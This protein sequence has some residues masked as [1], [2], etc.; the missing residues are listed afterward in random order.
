MVSKDAELP[1]ARQCKL[2]GIS[3][4]SWY[5]RAVVESAENLVL[6]RELDGLHLQ[7]P[8]LGSRQ[9]TAQL[10]RQGRRVNRKRVSRLMKR[11][12][13]E[14]SYPKKRTSK[15]AVGHTLYPYLLTNMTPDR[16]N[17]AWAAD[18]TYIPMAKG[19]CYLM[20][21]MD[22]YSRKI[23]SWQLSNTLDS[24][25]CTAALN[26]ALERYGIPEIFNTDQGAQ[27]TAHAFTRILVAHGVRISMDA[28]GRWIDN[29]FIE[30]FWR[31]IKYEEVYLHAYDD[32]RVARRQIEA[33]ITYYNHQRP[34]SS[35]GTQTP[36]EVYHQPTSILEAIGNTP[37]GFAL[38][39]RPCS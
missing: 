28:T 12:G 35:L 30:R 38:N 34:H 5:Y 14:A 19:F 8:Y 24:R 33:Y 11:L 3:R 15:P 27:F 13:I 25:F 22:V 20:A 26:D 29:V 36:D 2:V 31:T 4:S 17:Q 23:L 9:L 37:Q 7:R 18:I 21:I 6:A 32:L 16:P 39:S 10:R 1:L